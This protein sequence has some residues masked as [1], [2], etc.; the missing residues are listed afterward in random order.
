MTMHAKPPDRDL[1]AKFQSAK[2][3]LDDWQALALWLCDFL[4]R[5]HAA[6]D[7]LDRDADL[8]VA[9]DDHLHLDP[10]WS[11]AALQSEWS[12]LSLALRIARERR[13]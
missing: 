12:R 7:L 1:L 9:H 4:E 5:V 13:R 2:H 6:R 11:A 8:V 3:R 10:D